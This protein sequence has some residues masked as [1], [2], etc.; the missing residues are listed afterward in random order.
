VVFLW[1]GVINPLA[2]MKI[3]SCSSQSETLAL[4]LLRLKKQKRYVTAALLK[5]PA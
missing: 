1:I 4:P 3:Q 2:A 5:M